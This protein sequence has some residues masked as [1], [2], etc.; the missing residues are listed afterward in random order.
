MSF[1][2]CRVHGFSPVGAGFKPALQMKEKPFVGATHWVALHPP[3]HLEKGEAMRGTRNEVV[4]G[5][6]FK[7]APTMGN[8]VQLAEMR[9]NCLMYEA[10]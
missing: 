6:G 9:F 4:V 5:A 1:L 3:S 7:P 2:G 10:P 8:A